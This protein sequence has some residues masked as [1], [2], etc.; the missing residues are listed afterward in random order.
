[1]NGNYSMDFIGH[2]CEYQIQDL[3]TNTSNDIDN[4]II[5]TSN[6]LNLAN[7][8][9]SNWITNIIIQNSNQTNYTDI[10]SNKLQKDIQN[11]LNA[12]WNFNSNNILPIAYKNNLNNTIVRS[13]TLNKEIQFL[14]INANCYTKIDSNNKLN[15][16]HSCNLYPF[17]YDI[18]W[19]DVEGR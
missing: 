12:T 9:T 17:G 2:L 6:N 19:W 16:F 11:L 3:I 10:T 1:M 4:Y 18:G 14:D 5:A 7:I 13:T 8:N 15:V